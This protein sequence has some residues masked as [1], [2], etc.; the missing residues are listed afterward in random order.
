MF[1]SER[2]PDSPTWIVKTYG[3]CWF[4]Y[5][6]IINLLYDLTQFSVPPSGVSLSF[7]RRRL[8]CFKKIK[9]NPNHS[10]LG[11][12]IFLS[13]CTFGPTLPSRA[14]RPITELGF[15]PK[16]RRDGHF[17]WCGSLCAF[18]ENDM[19]FI[20]WALGGGSTIDHWCRLCC[21]STLSLPQRCLKWQLIL[22]FVQKY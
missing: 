21:I 6:V 10:I 12:P 7:Q 19:H 14:C 13:L 15:E 3:I 17:P 16:R 11:R 5:L 20:K 22:S 2:Y 9:I 18:W 8:M 4:W 1:V